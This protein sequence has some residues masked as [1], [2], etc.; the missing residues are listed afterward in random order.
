VKIYYDTGVLLKLYTQEPESAA[1]RRFVT[2]AGMALPFLDFHHSE[3]ASALHLKVF[4]RECSL[5]QANG[6]LADIEEDL[7]NDVLRRLQPEWDEVWQR[8]LELTRAHASVTGCRTLDT[9]HVAAAVTLGFRTFAT[10]DLRQSTL[11][12]RLGIGVCDPTTDRP[13]FPPFGK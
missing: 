2:S 5:Q 10:S 3:C 7:R 1:V 8:T 13:P 6:A 11:A 4:R 12:D 9:L